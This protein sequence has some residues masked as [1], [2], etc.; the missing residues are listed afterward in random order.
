MMHLSFSAL[1]SPPD[2]S[3]AVYTKPKW[4][5]RLCQCIDVFTSVPILQKSWMQ[6]CQR[7]ARANA[8]LA[9]EWA[10]C[11]LLLLASYT[12][13]GLPSV[14]VLTTHRS[15]LVTAAEP[16]HLPLAAISQ[17][18]YINATVLGGVKL[19]KD[20][21]QLILQISTRWT[22]PKFA[23]LCALWAACLTIYPLGW[24]GIPLSMLCAYP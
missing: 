7:V 2:L 15:A 14:L 20:V 1:M 17:L 16:P 5:Q 19:R 11:R 12:N 23:L 6:Y 8:C 3:G 24:T 9:A 18:R 10:S 13:L 22:G 4:I 21:W